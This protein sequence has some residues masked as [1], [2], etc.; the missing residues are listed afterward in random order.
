[1]QGLRNSDFLN[2]PQLYVEHDSVSHNVTTSCM[3]SS[4]APKAK[5]VTVGKEINP[6]SYNVMYHS[7]SSPF[8]CNTLAKRVAWW[9]SNSCYSE[10]HGHLNVT[11]WLLGQGSNQ[12]ILSSRSHTDPRVSKMRGLWGWTNRPGPSSAITLIG[13]S[14][15]QRPWGV[16]AS[17]GR[18]MQPPWQL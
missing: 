8:P 15:D 7:V 2:R 3:N 12:R 17:Y 16:E 14:T 5:D 1:M 10:Y 4:E 6:C 9:D 13:D 11:Y 18:C